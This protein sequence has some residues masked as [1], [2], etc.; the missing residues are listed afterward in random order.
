VGVVPGEGREVVVSEAWTDRA[1]H[2]RWR[3]EPATEALIA[4]VRAAAEG[5]PEVVEV[6]WRA[7]KGLPEP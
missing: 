7:G 4:R 2:A 5:P 1:A 3:E 6:A